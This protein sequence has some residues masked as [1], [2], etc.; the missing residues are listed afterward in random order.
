MSASNPLVDRRSVGISVGIV[1]AVSLLLWLRYDSL[2]GWDGLFYRLVTI[3][4]TRFAEGYSRD[5]FLQVAEGMPEAE[6]VGLLGPPLMK[7]G[8][9]GGGDA[10]FYSQSPRN[11][12]YRLRLVLFQDRRVIG[13]KNEYY[14]D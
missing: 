6:V 8:M 1:V 3:E 10:W 13:K 12:S 9:P 11:R 5:R 2:D 4:D 14:V 7:E